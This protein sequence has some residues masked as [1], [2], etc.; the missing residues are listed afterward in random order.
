MEFGS[1]DGGEYGERNG[2]VFMEVSKIAAT[3]VCIF[4]IISYDSV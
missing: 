2:V 3:P 1:L 4:G